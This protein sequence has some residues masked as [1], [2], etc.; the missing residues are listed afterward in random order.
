[1]HSGAEGKAVSEGGAS[2]VTGSGN[3]TNADGEDEE[4]KI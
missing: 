3:P 4:E 1:M 2:K